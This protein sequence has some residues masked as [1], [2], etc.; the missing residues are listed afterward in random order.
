[1][2]AGA[3]LNGPISAALLYNGN[4]V[5]GNTSDPNGKNLL[6][7]LSASGKLLDVRNVDKGPAG[8]LFGIV[9]TG[10]S[11]SDTA[12]YFN[13]DNDNNLQALVP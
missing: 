2:Y 1:M 10:T 4:L 6:V 9:A 12:V 11:T 8:A 3:P 13:D 7:E 5:V